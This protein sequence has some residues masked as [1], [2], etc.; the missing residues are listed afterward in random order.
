MSETYYVTPSFV[1]E[2]LE[3]M[4]LKDIPMSDEKVY[5]TLNRSMMYV[6]DKAAETV[7]QI[8]RK[9]KLRS[10]KGMGRG[11]LWTEWE[12]AADERT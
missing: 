4:G 3:K 5:V 11:C 12:E 6:E 7:W 2:L 1:E 9:N 8:D 10:H